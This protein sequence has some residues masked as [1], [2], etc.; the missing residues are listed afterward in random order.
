LGLAN[1]SEEETVGGWMLDIRRRGFPECRL[2]QLSVY[3]RKVD[4][5]SKLLRTLRI[6]LH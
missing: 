1:S 3:Q 4:S 2:P 5:R 6:R